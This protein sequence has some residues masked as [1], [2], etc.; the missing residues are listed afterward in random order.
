MTMNGNANA[1]TR[2]RCRVAAGPVCGALYMC[3]IITTAILAST[4]D[5]STTLYVPLAVVALLLVCGVGVVACAWWSM[6]ADRDDAG[7]RAPLAASVSLTSRAPPP[8]SKRV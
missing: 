8:P 5:D 7:A 3:V 2:D 6:Y 1:W 4:F